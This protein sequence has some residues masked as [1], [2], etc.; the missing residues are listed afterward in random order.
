MST[1]IGIDGGGTKTSAVAADE[2]GTV[3]GQV[4]A[5]PTNPNGDDIERIRTV[6]HTIKQQLTPFVSDWEDAVVFAGIAGVIHPVI[7]RKVSACLREVFSGVARL[8]L[9]HDGMNALA[10]VTYGDPGVVQI[11]G[12]G[13]LTF[14]LGKQGKRCR[15]GGWGYLIGDEGSGFDLGRRALIRVMKAYDGRGPATGLT[16]LALRK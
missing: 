9:D 4:T 16:E 8:D 11:A 14:G 15:I 12:T 7:H 6:F 13:S 2:R 10:A 3:L 5:G 1:F